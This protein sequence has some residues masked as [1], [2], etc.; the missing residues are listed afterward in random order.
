MVRLSDD[1]G[2]SLVDVD[3]LETGAIGKGN[4][5]HLINKK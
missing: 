2:V 1:W 4:K 5:T 3:V